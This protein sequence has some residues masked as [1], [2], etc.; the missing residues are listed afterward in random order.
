MSNHILRK[1][2]EAEEPKVSFSIAYKM[3]DLEG[4]D[5]LDFVTVDRGSTKEKDILFSWCKHF[6]MKGTPYIVREETQERLILWI[7]RKA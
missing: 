2:L 3:D 1:R 4:K 7:E 5:L 6:S